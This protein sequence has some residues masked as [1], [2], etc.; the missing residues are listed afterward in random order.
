[1]TE[2]EEKRNFLMEKTA[3]KKHRKRMRVVRRVKKGPIKIFN[4]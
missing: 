1:M 3:Q 2:R 4:I